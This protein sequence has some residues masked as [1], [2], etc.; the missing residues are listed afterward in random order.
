MHMPQ[1]PPPFE[2]RIRTSISQYTE[3][4]KTMRRIALAVEKSDSS[5]QREV[6]LLHDLQEQARR[7]DLGLLDELQNGSPS[8]L[9][10]PLVIERTEL[11][12]QV[13]DL[14]TSLVPKI[15]GAMTILGHELGTFKDGRVMM[16]G[17]KQ[18]KRKQGRILNCRI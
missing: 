12:Q 11:L 18:G 14:N 2:G 7:D 4:L 17:Y 10:H 9:Q 8:L 1:L 5:L 13:L 15:K 6:Q 3:I 16:T